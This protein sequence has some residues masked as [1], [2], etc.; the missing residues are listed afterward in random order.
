MT[1][2]LAESKI[3]K[4]NNLS[5]DNVVKEK[6]QSLSILLQYDFYVVI[7]SIAYV[8]LADLLILEKS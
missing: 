5:F 1:L 6:E 2:I 8:L 7:Y 3:K 4:L